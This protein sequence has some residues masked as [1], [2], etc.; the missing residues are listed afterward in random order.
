M[1]PRLIK[2]TIDLALDVQR[3]PG[4]GQRLMLVGSALAD[5]LELSVHNAGVQADLTGLTGLAYFK[6][7]EGDIPWECEVGGHLVAV[8]FPP[9]AYAFEGTL[10]VQ[11]FLSDGERNVPLYQEVFDIGEGRSD[12]L[13]DP[14]GIVPDLPSVL[15][16][17]GELDTSKTACDEATVAAVQA[18]ENAQSAAL[19]VENIASAANEALQTA[20]KA[21]EIASDAAEQAEEVIEGIQVTTEAANAAI[22]RVEPA[23]EAAENA[24]SGAASA[25][26]SASR[27]A[28]NAAAAALSANNAAERAAS[29][30]SVAD[31]VSLAADAAASRANTAAETLENAP[32]PT[33]TVV[34]YQA[35]ASATTPPSG[36]WVSSPPAVSQGQYLWTRTVQSFTNGSPVTSYSVARQGMDGSGSV[37]AVDGVSPD[38]SGNVQLG[39]VRSV[40]GNAPD[41][42]GNVEVDAGGGAV[43]TVDGISPDSSG[44]VEL[45]A[46]RS[47]NGSVPD[48]SGNIELTASQVGARPDTWTPTA[49]EV[50]AA[51]PYPQWSESD[52]AAVISD[53][54]ASISNAS[55]VSF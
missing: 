3:D 20:K 55:G 6:T 10:V 48:A 18:A 14:S 5:R 47:V 24:A 22:E 33:G 40:N 34:T 23:V 12:V 2:R 49:E 37:A 52:K 35:G 31:G 44:N 27:E 29:A 15:A 17:L 1:E 36:A 7:A 19:Q 38:A 9:E 4:W 43:Q 21:S 54:L 13:I 30:A 25:A 46:V 26:S 16:M 39:A 28:A 41:A 45:G 50:G 53:V 11:V 32:V 8:E 51:V 42:S